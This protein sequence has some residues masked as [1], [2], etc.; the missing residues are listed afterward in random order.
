VGRRQAEK[1][2]EN[3]GE[4]L[5]L[6]SAQEATRW[7]IGAF[8]GRSRAI[9]RV[10]EDVRRLQE[11]G[12]TSV[13][14]SGESGTG[15]E[16][17][18]RA[19]HFG[20]TRSEKLFVPVNCSA[21]PGELAESSFFGHERG[22]FTGAIEP[23]KGY[24]ELADGGTL[25]LDEIGDMPLGLQAKLLRALETGRVMPLGGAEEKQVDVRILAATNQDLVALIDAGRFRE[26]L[27]FRLTGFTVTVPP[28]RERLKD[29]PLLAEHFLTL[30]AAE[31]GREPTVLSQEALERVESYGFPGNVR[32]L[33]NVIEHALIVSD[34]GPIGPECLRFIERAPG[35]RAQS[36]PLTVGYPDSGAQALGGA[37]EKESR[38]AGAILPEEKIL[39]HVEERGN[40]SNTECRQLLS[41]DLQQASYLLKKLHENGLLERRGERRW[42]R[43]Y[44]PESTS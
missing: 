29:I 36:R 18:A 35:A 4:Q 42:S 37:Q 17:V 1:A 31:M 23:R 39:A 13:L 25:F 19:I 41:I 14:I 22:A 26:D 15:K 20:G 32:E 38:G 7:G 12:R 9:V 21:I 30:F 8:I 43:Y 24:F 6:L 2:L 44:L 40:I 27:Y 28:L 10:L 11:T 34:G 16:L 33:K 3:A 5:S